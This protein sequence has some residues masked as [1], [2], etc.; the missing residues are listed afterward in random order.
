[1][2]TEIEIDANEGVATSTAPI[3]AKPPEESSNSDEVDANKSSLLEV[4]QDAIKDGETEEQEQD[5]EGSPSGPES[6]SDSESESE[7][8][9]KKDEGNTKDEEEEQ[10]PFHEHPAW[11]KQ[12]EKRKAAEQ[13]FETSKPAV[14]EYQAIQQFMSQNDLTVDE[15]AQGYEI[16]ALMK[17]DPVAAHAQL[18]ATIERLAPFAGESLAPDLLEKVE[19][20]E[21][22]ES[23]AREL[24]KAQAG[25]KLAQGKLQRQQESYQRARVESVQNKM[26]TAVNAWEEAARSK[27]PGYGSKQRFVVTELASL[28]SSNPPQNAEEAIT[29][30]EQAY[31]N[32]N[33][34][35]GKMVPARKSVGESLNSNSSRNTAVGDADPPK[36]MEEAVNRALSRTRR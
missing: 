29:L 33:V 34:A 8:E 1:M 3:D 21:V 35:L 24:T 17:N 18:K 4:I 14:A 23:T 30:V 25:E 2:N 5:A 6:E 16:M 36:S 11:Q 20:G 27:D 26:V 32:V 12:I 15:V 28:R 7:A 19:S 10:P 22:D 13:A 31:S 9:P